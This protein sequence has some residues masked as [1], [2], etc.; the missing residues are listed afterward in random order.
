MDEL[1]KAIAKALKNKSSLSKIHAAI[2]T[3]GWSEE[4]A[5]LALKA[6]E[7]LYNANEKQEAELA[8]RPLPFGRKP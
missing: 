3:K 8:A 4:D 7:N 2:V 5:F 6:G 1:I